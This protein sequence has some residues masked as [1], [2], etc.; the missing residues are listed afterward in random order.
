MTAPALPGR[1]HGFAEDVRRIAP[2]A[3][4]VVIGQV[5]VLAFNTIDTVLV[6]RHSPADLA[7]FAVGAA[8]YVTVFV[9]FMG[10]VLAVSPIVG[11]LFGAGRLEAAGDE[12][13]QA[14]WLALALS[15]LGIVLLLFPQPFLWI[16]KAGP[17]IAERVHGYLRALAVALPASLLFTAFRGFNTAVSR[18]KV[19]MLLQIGGLVAKLPLSIALVFGVPAWGIPELGV[20]GA[21]IATA[22]ALWIQLLLACVMMR[23]DAFY[24]RFRL[25]GR[26]LHAPNR[27]ALWG[28]LRLGV[29]M[30]AAILIEVTGFSMMALLISRLG[31]LPVAGHQIAVNIVSLMFMLPL[32][33]A[34]AS[35]TLVAQR[36]GAGDLADARRLGWHGLLLGGLLAAVLGM[37]M[38]ATREPVIALYTRDA[39]VAAAAFPL[40]AWVVVFHLAD[41]LQTVAAFVL[42]AW[43]IATLPMFIY[44]GSLWGIGLVGGYTLGFDLTGATPP[45]LRGAP[46]FWAAS[47]A[48]LVVAGVALTL[49]MRLVLKAKAEELQQRA[50]GQAAGQ[51]AA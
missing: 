47:T 35:G 45:A 27:Q 23:R 11:Q 18:P 19:V 40:L 12:M 38:F 33:L 26:G 28:L 31:T 4:P 34:N 46:G 42:R 5:A 7:A 16:A 14:V 15:V 9:G 21:G 43:R 41:A 17:D 22:V 32:G 13:H 8:A 24:D 29:P 20:T 36:I 48:G 6:G 3:W 44:A 39:A 51:P 10:I 2:L 50:A 1:A 25:W 37:V 30:G 49:F